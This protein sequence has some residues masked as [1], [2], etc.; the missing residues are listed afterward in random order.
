M[1]DDRTVLPADIH[2]RIFAGRIEVESPGLLPGNVTVANIGTAGSRPRNRA[3]VDHLREFPTPPNLDAGEGVRMMM[4]T[5]DKANLYPPIFVTKPDVPREAVL[6]CLFNVAR[7]SVWDQV[8]AHLEK[9]GAVGNTEVRTVLRT[10]DPVKASRLL[11]TWVNLGLLVLSN[12]HAA[13]QHRR[14][15]RP[16]ILPEQKLFSEAVGK[17]SS[18][19]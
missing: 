4:D 11:K 8:S 18:N 17:Q 5:M 16:G 9:H 19:M 15:R 13:K 1:S 12:P 2:I 3:L 10:D 14:Y 6:L 7:P